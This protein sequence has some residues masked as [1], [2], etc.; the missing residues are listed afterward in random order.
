MR[1]VSPRELGHTEAQSS[2]E[3]KGTG[4]ELWFHGK[5]KEYGQAGPFAGDLVRER[6]APEGK[7]ERVSRALQALRE[8]VPIQLTPAQWKWVAEDPEAEDQA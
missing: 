6:F 5:E 1:N 4:L 2:W 8:E 7:A 3:F